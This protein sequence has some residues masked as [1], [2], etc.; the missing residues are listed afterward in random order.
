MPLLDR[1][2]SRPEWQHKDAEV[3]AAAVRRLGA[4]QQELLLTIARN[5]V[6]VRV[7]RLA[8]KKL[9]SPVTLGELA[10]T[11]SDDLI[12]ED[13][14]EILLRLALESEQDSLALPALETL[15]ET[16]HLQAVARSGRCGQARRQ[17]LARIRDSR[18][19]SPVARAAE[20]SGIRLSALEAMDDPAQLADVA[21][22]SEHKDVALAATLRLD[23]GALL[24]SVAARARS[25]AAARQ[26]RSMLEA[27]AVPP[28]V[29]PMEPEAAAEEPPPAAEAPAPEPAPA[30][31]PAADA[32][33]TSIPEEA[34][35][36]PQPS[37]L[38]RR[39]EEI[40]LGLE[41]LAAA[42][43]GSARSAAGE[44]RKRW[45]ELDGGS[46]EHDL[47]ERFQRADR[48]LLER[49]SQQREEG[50]RQRKENALRLEA[51]CER[52]F[53]MARAETVTLKDAQ[54][55][56]REL[57]SALDNPGSLPG[58]RER[59][60]ILHRLRSARNALFPRTQEL[61]EADEWTRWSNLSRQE[62]L[63]RRVE[64]LLELG[65]SLEAGRRLRD[66]EAEWKEVRQVPRD[67]GE[68]LW[69][70]FRIARDEVRARSEAQLAERAQEAAA[71]LSR[72]EDLCAQAEALADSS[73]WL[74]T[75]E[76]LQRL[77]EEWKRIGTI[78]KGKGTALWDRFR[79][80]CDRFFERRKQDLTRRR[81]DWAQNL[82]AKEALCEAAEALAGSTDWERTA[83]EIAR[84]Q[85]EW[86]RIGAVRKN[87]SD[88]VWQRFRSACAGF[89]ER[90]R[91][92]DALDRAARVA[93]RE[94]VVS[95][96]E[97]LA[98]A[99]EVSGLG[100]A[101]RAVMQQ[102]SQLGPPVEEASLEQ[103]FVV[104][105]D[106]VLETQPEAFRGTELD[107]DAN[108]AKAEKLCARV[109]AVLLPDIEV[110]AA[111]LVDRLREALAANTMGARADAES[112]WRT[113]AA[114]VEAAQQAWKRL[115]PLPGDA[116]RA[117]RERF[118][119]ACRRFFSQRP[120]RGR[121]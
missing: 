99:R 63:C 3:R 76:T 85:A 110:D 51:L 121:S 44:L 39:A 34:T 103:R 62:D 90:Y 114:E 97:E 72:K 12:R 61:R 50:T 11:D 95:R 52:A 78:P 68:A 105:R 93:Q 91:Q 79:A 106:R 27:R 36:A 59:Q 22:R 112:R 37:D 58:Q 29:A 54:A 107:P 81:R 38:R 101:V 10:R 33:D 75:A 83:G 40:C 43:L 77:Q 45:R 111:S 25:K 23:D 84:L 66:L 64:A 96:L 86:K 48:A 14:G 5:D 70:R 7:R 18:A 47:L 113:S 60:V 46:V 92:R 20:D 120:S 102:W 108:R 87:R 82:K 26:A 55:L 6:D 21:L 19:L 65:D 57:K 98:G 69:N 109:E 13:A 8:V 41:G 117:L 116:G 49:E 71:N 119:A 100:D 53:T 15:T 35:A 73:D 1:F 80:A 115:G 28:P 67:E 17:A 104:A 9:T 32:G 31:E 88:A 4:E 30:D 56:M 89:F 94:Q 42:D 118:D 74:K 24:E 2:R 16:R